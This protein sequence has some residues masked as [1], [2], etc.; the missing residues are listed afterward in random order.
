MPSRDL[1]LLLLASA[2][3]AVGGLFMKWSDGLTRVGPTIT[4][5]VLFLLGAALQALAMR[6]AD[7]G[8]AYI[9]VLG[10]EAVV[11]FGL[12]VL[13]LGETLNAS[14]ITAVLLILGGILLLRRA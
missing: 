6:T 12:S 8:V 2:A 11:A 4:V 9:F 14:R 10:A 1:V 7:L 13:V 5:A 3:F